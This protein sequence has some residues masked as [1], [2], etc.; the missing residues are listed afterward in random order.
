[1]PINL[2]EPR[3]CGLIK[4]CLWRLKL[5]FPCAV[6]S[7]VYDV[8]HTIWFAVLT[9]R[10]Q[11]RLRCSNRESWGKPLKGMY[12]FCVFCSTSPLLL[13]LRYTP[14][15]WLSLDSFLL[16]VSLS[17]S[18]GKD[19]QHTRSCVPW[20][21]TSINQISST[22]SCILP[23][24]MPSGTPRRSVQKLF[25]SHAVFKSLYTCICGCVSEFNTYCINIKLG[26]GWK[27]ILCSAL[28]SLIWC[29][30]CT[31]TCC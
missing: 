12:M 20:P 25:C 3:N 30:Q 11:M 19:S 18:S 29:S 16:L 21:V 13:S 28:E 27:C 31:F 5:K 4:S 8:Y 6:D 7:I 1:M 17:F 26:R 22:N 14:P 9:R 10:W 2:N 24:T 23:T 15:F